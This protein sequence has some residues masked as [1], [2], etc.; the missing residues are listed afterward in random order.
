MPPWLHTLSGC[1]AAHADDHRAGADRVG[2][3]IQAG[4]RDRTVGR[5]LFGYDRLA[6]GCAA[7]G[8]RSPSV[9][10]VQHAAYVFVVFGLGSEDGIYLVV[11]DGGRSSLVR[12]L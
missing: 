11:Q 2:Q 8:Y 5:Q 7:A 9:P 12:D 4:Q 10:S 6:F 3:I 1:T